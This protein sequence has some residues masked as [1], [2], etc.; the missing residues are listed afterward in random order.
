MGAFGYWEVVVEAMAALR[1]EAD[2]RRVRLNGRFVDR[3]I[4]S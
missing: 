2:V 1:D 4:V 3:K